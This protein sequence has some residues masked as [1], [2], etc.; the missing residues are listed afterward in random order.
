VID[1]PA[2]GT[3]LAAISDGVGSVSGFSPGNACARMAVR[4]P[5]GLTQLI[6]SGRFF[7]SSAQERASAS[8]AAFEA[9]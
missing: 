3:I 2:S 1:G 6:L 4:V 9:A 5:P 7:V 8:T